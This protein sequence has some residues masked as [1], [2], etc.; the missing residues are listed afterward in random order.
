[1]PPEHLLHLRQ[2]VATRWGQ[3][4]HL[5][6]GPWD[7]FSHGF[8]MLFSVLRCVSCVLPWFFGVETSVCL[9]SHALFSSLIMLLRC[10]TARNDH[11]RPGG[12]DRPGVQVAWRLS[13]LLKGVLVRLVSALP[14]PLGRMR[15]LHNRSMYLVESLVLLRIDHEKAMCMHFV[16]A[17]MPCTVI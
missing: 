12:S 1:M 11:K 9:E 6:G 3:L 15:S 2:A 16:D 8:S 7:Q 5:P 10:F 13:A 14:E 17:Y 4:P